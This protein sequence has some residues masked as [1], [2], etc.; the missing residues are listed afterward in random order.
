MPLL[1]KFISELQKGNHLQ[2]NGKVIRNASIKNYLNLQNHLQT[3][4]Q[5]R[6]LVLRICDHDKL[7]TREQRSEKN[8]WKRFYLTFTDYL[9]NDIGSY[10]NHAGSMMKLLRAFFNYLNNEFIIATGLYHNRF[11]I[12]QQDIPVIVLYP[13]RLN[14]LIHN[15][16]FENSLPK[17][18]KAHKD[19]FVFGCTTALR[20]SDLVKLQPTNLETI[21]GNVYLCSTSQKTGMIS[22]VYLPQYA[23]DILSKYKRRKRSLFKPISKTN[24]NI[25]IKKIAF[26]A[27]W[28]EPMIKTR[29]KRGESENL[30]RDAAKQE[31]YRFCDLVSSHTMRR[32][33][34]TTLLR[35]GLNEINVRI[36]S[37]HRANSPS[38]YRYVNYSDSFMNEELDKVYSK[39]D[40]LAEKYKSS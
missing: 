17:Y 14:F 8:Y 7:N 22:R 38:F 9:F 24:F 6:G 3:Y 27:G 39:M 34:I 26:L 18:L 20:F 16:E 10:D 30:Y 21:N 11:Y 13:E 40:A 35:M 15:K 4:S 31:H 37:G 25:A 5:T 19:M 29:N 28:T 12:T 2:K 36:I 32:T 1:E 33:A 23:K